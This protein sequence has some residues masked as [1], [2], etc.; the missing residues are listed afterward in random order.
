MA[1]FKKRPNDQQQA[2][3][4]TEGVKRVWSKAPTRE[5]SGLPDLYHKSPMMAPVNAIAQAVASTPFA[6]YGKLDLR[7]GKDSA[8]PIIEHELYDLFEYPIKRYPEIDCY[9]LLYMSEVWIKL[10]GEAFWLKVR[11]GSGRVIELNPLPPVWITNTPNAGNPFFQVYPLGVTSGRSFNVFPDDMV[12]FKSPDVVDPYGRGRGATEPLIDEMESDEYMSKM[13]KNFAFNDATPPYII[14]A[15][16]M[17]KDQAE[18]FKQSWT[19]KLGGWMHRREPGVLGFDAKVLP[20]SMTPVEM[21]MIESRKFVRDEV[22]QYYRIPPEILGNIANSN[23]ST[24]DAADYL[25]YKNVLAYEYSFIERAIDRQ[26]ISVDFDRNVCFRFENTVPE[27]EERKLAVFNAG[28][29]KG[30]ISV[31][32][33][34]TAFNLPALGSR[35][36]VLLRGFNIYEVP[37][38]GEIEIP[39][40]E[41]TA[42]QTDEIETDDLATDAAK[43]FM[44]LI[45][46]KN[47]ELEIYKDDPDTSKARREAIWKA[48]DAKAVSHEKEFITAVKKYADR[49]K[50]KLLEVMNAELDANAS[51][52]EAVDKAINASFGK[53]ADTALKS[54]LA[55]AWLASMDDGRKLALEIV[56]PK[57][58]IKETDPNFEVTRQEFNAWI[59]KYGLLKATEINK[60]T[61]NILRRNLMATIS[62]DI[63][64]GKTM[65]EMAKDLVDIADEVYDNMSASR[66]MLIARTE[67]ATT[68][69]AG[70][71]ITYSNEGVEKKQWMSALDDRTRGM[72]QD[73]EFDH[74]HA[75]GE[76]VNINQPFM[77]TGE[78]LMYPGDPNGSAGNN[79]NCR[80]VV[81]PVI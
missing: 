11:D 47:A 20:L 44:L 79:C 23:R 75:D 51:P 43:M 74:V 38:A 60:T 61:F 1:F 64:D 2:P 73:D 8:E 71:F 33:W 66:A 17:Q 7:R 12:W 10:I 42:E 5:K 9:S 65:R 63:T 76:E 52:K 13:Q 55:P 48:F 18:S 27:D 24:I 22:S 4:N 36:D 80:C 14:T 31:N 69:N 19:Q 46:R 59:E 21:D 29:E 49:Q 41:E 3:R 35:G 16:G 81:L 50:S 25:F 6:L 68:V 70:Q 40:P 28:L 72:Y 77:A 15:P 53:Q 37:T 67:T 78:A 62:Q 30:T 58:S 34:R 26:L 45:R 54:A 32:E 39:E 56:A 57:K